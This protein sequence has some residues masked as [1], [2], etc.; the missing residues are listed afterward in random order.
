MPY[1]EL[2]KAN[3]FENFIDWWRKYGVDL[4]HKFSKSTCSDGF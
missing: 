2:V 4:C 1:I 3:N